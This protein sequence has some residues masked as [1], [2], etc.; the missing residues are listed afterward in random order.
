MFQGRLDQLRERLNLVYTIESFVVPAGRNKYMIVDC[1]HS[2]KAG[3]ETR[4]TEVIP[5]P[6]DS[7]FM[8]IAQNLL[9]F[10][11]HVQKIALSYQMSVETD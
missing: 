7:L 6:E 10:S 4:L 1:P 2:I 3:Q 8:H 5:E 11:N 9:M